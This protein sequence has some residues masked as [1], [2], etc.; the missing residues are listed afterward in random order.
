MRLPRVF[1]HPRSSN[2]P[3]K[4]LGLGCGLDTCLY[5]IPYHADLH[6]PLRSPLNTW[7]NSNEA[8]APV[9]N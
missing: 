4:V 3:A 7:D 8:D 1:N 2:S 6:L 9:L 5:E